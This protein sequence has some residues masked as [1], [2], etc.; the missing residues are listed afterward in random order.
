MTTVNASHEIGLQSILETIGN[1]PLI[2]LHRISHGIRTPI[3]AKAEFFNPGG[4][5]KDRIGLAIIEDAEKR[6]ELKHGGVIVEGTS[7]NTG[8]GLALA[9]GASEGPASAEPKCPGPST[10]CR[11]TPAPTL[12]GTDRA[13]ISEWFPGFGTWAWTRVS[14]SR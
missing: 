6:G 11:P 10:K 3:Y 7:G 8:V 4:S 5:V 2:R 9:G 14:Y 12:P 1:T 13:I